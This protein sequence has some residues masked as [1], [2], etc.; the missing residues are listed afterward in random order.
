MTGTDQAIVGAYCD[1]LNKHFEIE[2]KGEADYL[3]GINIKQ[4][5]G[6]IKLHQSR[7]IDT[8]VN[9]H[10]GENEHPAAYPITSKLAEICDQARRPHNTHSQVPVAGWLV[11]VCGHRRAP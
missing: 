4:S 1:S 7:Y 11:C 9:E 3:L 5:D 10:L 8:L 2:N 6:K